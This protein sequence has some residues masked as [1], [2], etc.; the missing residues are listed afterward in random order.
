MKAGV[1]QR[2]GSDLRLAIAP[3]LL[4]LLPYSYT[5]TLVRLQKLDLVGIP[6]FS[7]E[8]MENWGIITFRWE[9]EEDKRGVGG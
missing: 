8:A 2:G 6:E 3:H 7:A 4:S 9:R 1:E 5:L